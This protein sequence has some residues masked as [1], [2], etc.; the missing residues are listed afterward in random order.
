MRYKRGLPSRSINSDSAIFIPHPLAMTCSAFMSFI[1]VGCSKFS[2]FSA[3]IGIS[4]SMICSGRLKFPYRCVIGFRQERLKPY[5]VNTPAISGEFVIKQ[6]NGRYVLSFVEKQ[7][8]G[9]DHMYVDEYLSDIW[10]RL[11]ST[12][13]IKIDN[14]F[15]QIDMASVGVPPS[16][17][18]WTV[19]H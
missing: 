2:N 16:L 10:S 13:H 5:P 18:E 15:Y 19:R 7:F 9:V 11:L 4:F 14:S 17:N 6:E 12:H 1:V 8:G 3:S